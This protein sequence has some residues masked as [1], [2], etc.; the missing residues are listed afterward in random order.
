MPVQKQ[1]GQFEVTSEEGRGIMNDRTWFVAVVYGDDQRYIN[2][3]QNGKK[4]A[5]TL[6]AALDA[7]DETDLSS[8]P[9]EFGPAARAGDEWEQWAGET[10]AVPA[11]I[12]GAGK[13]PLAAYLKVVHRQRENWIGNRLGVSEQTVR[14]YLSDL[15]EGRR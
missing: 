11:R 14:Q 9:P 6:A 10:Q 3:G 15:R 4:L 13:A 7:A 8:L 12:A 2:T 1:Y 5:R